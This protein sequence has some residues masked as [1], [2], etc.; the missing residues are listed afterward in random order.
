MWV[1]A[2]F[3][4]A[5]RPVRTAPCVPQQKKR[6]SFRPAVRLQHDRSVTMIVVRMTYMT[7]VMTVLH[8]AF[9]DAVVLALRDIR[10]MHD[11]VVRSYGLVV[12]RRRARQRSKCERG[13]HQGGNQGFHKALLVSVCS[14]RNRGHAIINASR[15]KEL[16]LQQCVTSCKSRACAPH[17]GR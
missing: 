2:D 10:G 8:M 13:P 15:D 5:Q 4:T 3:C 7:H 12:P 16:T 14:P 9:V 6:R 17:C 1:A 11:A